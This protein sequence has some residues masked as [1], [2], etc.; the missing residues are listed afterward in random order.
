[1]N[2]LSEKEQDSLLSKSLKKIKEQIYFINNTISQNKL[3]QCLKESFILLNELRTNN[4][5]PGRYYTLYMSI[6]DIMLNIKNFF[7]E[8]ISKGR[9]LIELYD[10][11]QQAK[12]AIPRIYLMII[13]GS[14][15]MEKVPKSVHVILFDLLGVVKQ[16]QN[17]V[18]GLFIRNYLLKMVKDKLPDKGNIYEKEGGTFEDSVKFLIQNIEEMTLLWVRLLIGVEGIEKKKREIERDELKILIGESMY[19]LSSLESL[20]KEIYEEQILP[21]LLK[22]IID[23]KDALSQQYLMECIIHSFPNSYNI[24]CIEQILDTMTQLEEG[25]DIGVLFINLMDKIGQ[26]FGDVIANNNNKDKDSSADESFDLKDIIKS[27]KDIYPVLLDN[28]EVIMNSNIN[29]EIKEENDKKKNISNMPLLNLLDLICSFFIFFIKCSTNEQ[30]SNA[31]I[32]IINY[33]I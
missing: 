14:I 27:A 5:T 26:Y 23:S 22:V 17:P 15:Y 21:K 16:V 4:L 13:V 32:K 9:A 18:K 7:A 28:F 1:M 33:T 11:V 12:Y 8:E 29:K 24:K 30:R 2:I 31:V 20:N 25:V 19:K 3:R 10:K 6:F